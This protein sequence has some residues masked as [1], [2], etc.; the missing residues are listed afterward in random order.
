MG[1]S[2]LAFELANTGS[3]SGPFTGFNLPAA[4][5]AITE[6]LPLGFIISVLSWC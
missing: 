4:L 6:Q 2:G 5:Q 3:V 1:G